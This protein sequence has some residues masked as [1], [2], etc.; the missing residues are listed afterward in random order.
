MC[1][2]CGHFVQGSKIE[3]NDIYDMLKKRAAEAGIKDCRQPERFPYCGI[4]YRNGAL[5][6]K[7]RRR[8][9]YYPAIYFL[10]RKT[11]TDS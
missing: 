7:D 5:K 11:D 1:T 4:A 3:S 6:V 10:R 8:R 9:E 2:I